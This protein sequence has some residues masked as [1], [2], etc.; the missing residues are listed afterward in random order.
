M[1]RAALLAGLLALPAAAQTPRIKSA[2]EFL[3]P[4]LKALQADETANPGMLWVDDGAR[5]WRETAPDGKSCASCHGDATESMKGAAAR[6]PQVGAE[7]RLL[8]LEL[9][10]NECRTQRQIAPAFAYESEPLLALTTYVARQSLGMPMAVKTDDSAATFYKRGEAFF[11]RRQGQLNLS[12]AQCH[13]GVAG[14]R[15]RADVISNGAINAYP[16]YRLEWQTLGSLH[17]RLRACSLG[18]RATQFNHG[19]DEY[20]SLELYLAKRSQDLRIESPGVRK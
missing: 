17:R 2:S 14:S 20:L 5:L 19:S 11:H 8:N 15:L 3:S 12:C 10:I 1:L 18:V 9:R 13:D 6:Y 4:D 7:G 16:A